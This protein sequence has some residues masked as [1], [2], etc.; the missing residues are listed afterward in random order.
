MTRL[1]ARLCAALLLAGAGGAALAADWGPV[2]AEGQGESVY[3]D[4]AS[5][6]REGEHVAL[7]AKT[8]F[9]PPRFNT[10]LK[11]AVQA[12]LLHALVDCERGT[13]SMTAAEYYDAAGKSLKSIAW[14]PEEQRFEAIP[15]GSAIDLMRQRACALAKAKASLKPQV[16]KT[17]EEGNWRN[18]GP[19]PRNRVYS[20]RTD[21]I[22]LLK[23]PILMA[24]IRI[25][26]PPGAHTDAGIGYHASLNIAAL[27]CRSARADILITD[28]YDSNGE[29]VAQTHKEVG[30]IKLADMRPG[31]PADMAREA[32]CGIWRRDPGAVRTARADDEPSVHSGTGWLTSKG[33]LVTAA[34]V[35]AGAEKI[36]LMQEG[37]VVGE[38]EVAVSD[39]A[40]D[41]ALLRPRFRDGVHAALA[42][43]RAPAALGAHVFTLGYPAPDVMG[44]GIKMTS[45]EVSAL[46]GIS[47]GN[48]DDRRFLQVSIPIQPGNS[49][50]PVIDEGGA[51][52]GIVVTR[53]EAVGE[54]EPA[55]NVNYALKA[56]Y[57][58]NALAE[59]PDIGGYPFARHAGDA[60][61]LTAELKDAVFLIIAQAGSEP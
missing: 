32:V 46:A 61:A 14:G 50:G 16:S 38:A 3:V 45:G 4:S 59:L 24:I 22:E 12:S 29:L 54:D 60:A 52:V 8:E 13:F 44:V 17:L 6:R 40:N 15:P 10:V 9:D 58:R 30:E 51:V 39:P 57:V 31:S 55:Q 18:L 48:A 1:L 56:S 2:S 5:V 47:K 35:V 20:V 41:V 53:L 7:W 23:D 25:D 36:A 26:E 11:K 19:D 27:D 37:K 34:H 21:R 42:M 28:Y 49:G 33:Y 43:R